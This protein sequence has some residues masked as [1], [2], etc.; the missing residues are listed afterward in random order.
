MAS[1]RLGIMDPTRLS[2]GAGPGAIGAEIANIR[3]QSPALGSFSRGL[4]MDIINDPSRMSEDEVQVMGSKV[5]GGVNSIRRAPRNSILVILHAGA[6]SSTQQDIILCYPF[7]SPH[8][9]I[10]VKPGE[11]VWIYNDA[12]EG[13]SDHLYWMSRIVE[14]DFCDDVN[15]T[16]AER[17]HDMYVDKVTVNGALASASGDTDSEETRPYDGLKD[18]DKVPGP[19]AFADG[20]IDDDDADPTVPLTA[21]GY[22]VNI[23]DTIRLLSIASR[24]TTYEPVPR[25]TKRP[26]DF[27]LQGSNNA[28][29]CLGQ[30][31]GWT[32]T[33]RPDEAQ[34]SNSAIRPAEFS[35]TIDIVTGRGRFFEKSLP[36]PDSAAVPGTQPR[37]I[38][39]TREYL[40][41]D[42]N[43][44]SFIND[45][46][47]SSIEWNR[48]DRPQEGDPDFLTDASRIYVSMNSTADAS[49]NVGVNSISPLFEGEIQDIRGP[50]VVLKSDEVR[51]IARKE[52]DR[53]AINGSIRLIKE[54]TVGEDFAS[55][56]LLP[57]GVV[58]ITGS[59]I[60]IGQP[61]QGSGPG[62]KRSE[63]YVK[64]S[65]LEALLKK[66]FDNIDSFCQTLLTHTTPGYGS[67]SLQINQAA[68]SLQSE[69]AAR[70]NEIEKL[71]SA[72]IFGE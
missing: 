61:D 67:P 7:F 62:E 66:V 1:S 15:F 6:G 71:K 16:H 28:L 12:P 30:D 47:R 17:K 57:D 50:F 48:V 24:D 26:G 3:R 42:K 22:Q 56:Y 54:G 29:I 31:R 41:V 13:K 40:E 27:V 46:S 35:G 34:N 18:L 8:L 19:P 59:K 9:S 23:Y 70:K 39:N 32:A 21:D 45:T 53:Q 33:A 25:Y 43:P 4:V 55:I 11:H 63:P 58:Q 68:T 72:R 14:P 65:E 5:S 69:A 37:V 52:I 2:N 64:Y 10:P 20:P 60:Y 49:F 36:N 44:A 51:L 38:M